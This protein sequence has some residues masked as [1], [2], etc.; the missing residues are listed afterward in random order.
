MVFLAGSLY[1]KKLFV[2]ALLMAQI[3]V[4]GAL[5]IIEAEWMWLFPVCHSILKTHYQNYLRKYVFS[6]WWSMWL[7][8]FFIILLMAISYHRVKKVNLA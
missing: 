7:F 2:F 8:L 6:P 3:A 5:H 4:G 1:G